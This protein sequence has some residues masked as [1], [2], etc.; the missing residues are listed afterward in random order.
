MTAEL[1]TKLSRIQGLQVASRTSV[2]RFKGSE[3][4]VKEIGEE[5]AVRYLL[6]GSVRK[7]GDRVRINAQLID[8]STGFQVW[9]DDFDGELKDVF[10]VQEETALKIAEALN[11][12]LSPQ[13]AEALG[14]RDTQ[15]AE[16]YDAY[17][18]GWALVQLFAGGTDDPEKLEAARKH[19]ERALAL[20]PNYALALTG[21]SEIEGYYYFFGID[22]APARVQ[23]AEQ[24]A[25][26]ALA[27]D[28]QL[29]EA[30]VALGG[31]YGT[32]GHWAR[33]IEA[34]RQGL[35]LDPRNA[36][37]WEEL[38]WAFIHQD[39]QEAEKAAREAIGLQPGM[40]WA[41]FQ[42]GRALYLQTRYQ[43]AIG[44]F[45]HALQLNPAFQSAH[46]HLGH[47]YLDQGDYSRA[48][49]Q[50]EDER[51]TR[52]NPRLLRDIAAAHAGLGDGEKALAVLED[53][54]A[55]GYSDF[56]VIDTSSHFAALRTDPRFQALLAKYEN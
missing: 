53:A 48:L 26:R 5:L 43:E 9:S 19:F 28:P 12:H 33:A 46:H 25:L 21:L 56:A 13:E 11:L 34:F 35:R 38:A 22:A 7:A 8:A 37:G 2:S 24:L 3:K 10:A 4:G 49:A 29:A 31:L 17:L 45:E 20:D 52:E 1:T 54:L 23:R 6:E 14:R 40:F 41:Y 30:Y 36:Y 44:A 47:V 55:S 18:R 42:L 50:F 16:A 51:D 27:I 15:H 39:P 32:Q